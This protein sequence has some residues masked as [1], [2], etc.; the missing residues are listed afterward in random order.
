MTGRLA[1][2]PAWIPRPPRRAQYSSTC[3]ERPFAVWLMFGVNRH[4]HQARTGPERTRIRSAHLD[5]GADRRAVPPAVW[6]MNGPVRWADHDVSVA[7]LLRHTGMA[8]ELRRPAL[9]IPAPRIGARFCRRLFCRGHRM[10]PASFRRNGNNGRRDYQR[11]TEV[12]AMTVQ[13]KT[14]TN[15]NTNTNTFIPWTSFSARSIDG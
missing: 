6:H 12:P 8:L 15:T 5:P 2:P 14:N 4:S 10:S 3:D 13:T 7:D 9:A 11:R 1:V